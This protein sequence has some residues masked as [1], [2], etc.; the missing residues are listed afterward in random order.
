MLV[1]EEFFLNNEKHAMAVDNHNHVVLR[2]R[3]SIADFCGM[4]FF[5]RKA[6]RL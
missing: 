2:F 6:F 3:L 4:L 5:L 1:N